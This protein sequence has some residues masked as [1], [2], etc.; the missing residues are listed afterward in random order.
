MSAQP[1][2]RWLLWR[3]GVIAFWTDSVTGLWAADHGTS[4]EDSWGLIDSGLPT[5]A[6]AEEA[7]REF[8]RRNGLAAVRV[9]DK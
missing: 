4:S 6:A 5:R 2:D 3:G 7:A 1:P 8:L 9:I